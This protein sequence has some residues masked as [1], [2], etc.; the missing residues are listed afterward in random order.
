M[1][2]AKK[3]KK[4]TAK[5]RTTVRGRK[6]AA[7][8][9]VAKKVSAKKRGAKKKTAKK[10]V[11]KKR[12]A[13]KKV[14][15]KKVA[16]KTA[17]KKAVA[18]KKTPNEAYVRAKEEKKLY[19]EV[20][21][22]YRNKV[23]SIVKQYHT[24]G[25]VPASK[26]LDT[27]DGIAVGDSE[28]KAIEVVLQF[29]A[30]D[31]VDDTNSILEEVTLEVDKRFPE[32]AS[33]DRDA[34]QSYLR[35]IGKY[36]LLT[37]EEE[38]T[39]SK[40][41]AAYQTIVS[42]RSRRAL[43]PAE[44]RKILKEGREARDLLALSNLRLV[45]S[46]A[47]NYANR[48]PSLNLLDLAHEGTQGLYKAVDKFDASRGYKFSTYATWWIK[49]SIVRGLADKGMTIRIPVHMSETR[50]R[51][52]KANVYLEQILGRPPTIQ[53]LATELDMDAER[54]HV[55]RRISQGVA[56]LDKTIGSDEEGG[57]RLV[58]TILDE[59]EETSETITS[60][61][62]LKKQ[63]NDVLAGLGQRERQVLELRHGMKD[64]IQYTL[65]QIGAKLGVTRERV[66]QI[67]A[68]A[69]EKLKDNENIAKLR[70][71]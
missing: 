63:V 14:A 64:G 22:E 13:K 68:K 11:A 24:K 46:I 40:K 9:K 62:I 23:R 37:A 52:E 56:Q 55:I 16:K 59:N 41:I 6:V 28:W 27:L 61:N 34:I 18:K 66:R 47:K 58:D 36:K 44:K 43:K 5:K 12:V 42:G 15:K 30:I 54:I 50:Q 4:V 69:L 51:Y 21:R 2:V 20:A 17:A 39:L 10:T 29:N 7:K 25:Y 60:K 57:T 49:Q 65:E 38:V 32:V 8:K 70:S 31:L 45:I 53:E 33:N 26:L 67:E 35:D 1:A 71:Y 48:N 19:E 3:K